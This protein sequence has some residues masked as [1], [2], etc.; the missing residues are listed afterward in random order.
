MTAGIRSSELEIVALS[1]GFGGGLLAHRLMR[2]PVAFLLLHLLFLT[3]LLTV[4]A[5]L[6]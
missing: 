5:G 1:G 4:L 6:R 3:P 2:L